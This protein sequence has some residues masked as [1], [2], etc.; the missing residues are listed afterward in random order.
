[1]LRSTIAALFAWLL[2]VSEGQAQNWG[3]F[4]APPQV[5]RLDNGLTVVTVPWPAEGIVAYYTLVRVGAF[6][7]SLPWQPL[8]RGLLPNV[9]ANVCRSRTRGKPD[10][11]LRLCVISVSAACRPRSSR[12]RPSLTQ[13]SPA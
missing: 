2:T 11:G 5:T 10:S 6:I 1:M 12:T 9:T 8:F 3:P 4:A 7:L 13:L